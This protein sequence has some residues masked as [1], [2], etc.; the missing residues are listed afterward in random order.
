[1]EYFGIRMLQELSQLTEKW[2][3]TTLTTMESVRVARASYWY[4]VLCHLADPN[5]TSRSATA[6]ERDVISL[7]DLLEPWEVE[8][9]LSLFQSVKSFYNDLLDIPRRD[10]HPEDLPFDDQDRSH[11]PDGAF[12][13][14][15][16]CKSWLALPLLCS[17]CPDLFSK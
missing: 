10:L 5:D 3:L 15:D 1:M 14:N 17:C 12:H 7:L 11:T 8:E 13:L 9:L 4:Q 6:K 2:Q 16:F